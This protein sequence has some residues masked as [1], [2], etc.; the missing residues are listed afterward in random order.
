MLYDGVFY[1]VKSGGIVTTLNPA[2]GALLKQGRSEKAP[3]DYY[4]SPVAA[5]GKVYLLS[6]EGKMTVL[7][8]GAQWEV[9]AVNDLREE[10]NATPAISAGRI[11]VRTHETLY[12][13]GGAG[14]R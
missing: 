12:A 5:D 2:T 7:K 11:F 9:L 10:C 4:A 8:A 13:F 14:K 6:E 1:M 3:G